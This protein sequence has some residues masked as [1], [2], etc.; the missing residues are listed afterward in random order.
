MERFSSA[1]AHSL[2]ARPVG[3]ATLVHVLQN[4]AVRA[5]VTSAGNVLGTIEQ[6]LHCGQEIA[7]GVVLHELEAI[8]DGGDG[9]MGPARATVLRN[10]LVEVSGAVVDSADVAPR[11]VVGQIGASDV[12]LRLC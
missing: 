9:T 10:V 7:N 8:S 3:Q 12:I 6:N 2:L 11:E 5:S 1:R 4:S